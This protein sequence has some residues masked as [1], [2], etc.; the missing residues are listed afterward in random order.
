MELKNAMLTQMSG[1]TDGSA[2]L[3]FMDTTS[4]EL[5]Q[6]AGKLQSMRQERDEARQLRDNSLTAV[7]ALQVLYDAIFMLI[8]L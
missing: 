3:A 8:F 7:N 6:A 1:L 5:Q 2:V 4:R